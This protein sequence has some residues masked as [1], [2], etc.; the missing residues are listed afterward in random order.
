MSCIYYYQEMS[1]QYSGGV[2]WPEFIRARAKEEK[3]LEVEDESLKTMMKKNRAR[4]FEFFDH[5]SQLLSSDKGWRAGVRNSNTVF[6]YDSSHPAGHYDAWIPE[7]HKELQEEN[8]NLMDWRRALQRLRELVSTLERKSPRTKQ[9]EAM[10]KTLSKRIQTSYTPIEQSRMEYITEQESILR[11]AINLYHVLN[12]KAKQQPVQ[13]K[14]GG[15]ESSPPQSKYKT[16]ISF[17]MQ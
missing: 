12:R 4:R 15:N 16:Y 3:T 13:P 8:K 10:L 17:G 7:L 2:E 11:H 1:L 14:R 5:I 6:N 9:E